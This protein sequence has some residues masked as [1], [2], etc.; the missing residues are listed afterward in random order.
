MNADPIDVLNNKVGHGIQCGKC[1]C[2]SCGCGADAGKQKQ[3]KVDGIDALD[4]VGNQ[5]Q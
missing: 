4:K 5:I 2:G 3:E 1:C